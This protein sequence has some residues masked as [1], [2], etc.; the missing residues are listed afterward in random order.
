[1]VNER[2]KAKRESIGEHVFQFRFSS[3]IYEHNAQ[4]WSEESVALVSRPIYSSC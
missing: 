2:D 4:F 1:M 3:S